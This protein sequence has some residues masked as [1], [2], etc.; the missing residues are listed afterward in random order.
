MGI[1]L[2][3]KQAN[4]K[5]I[6]CIFKL[7]KELIDKYENIHIINYERVMAWVY[8]KIKR[9]ISEYTCIFYNNKKG[10][11]FPFL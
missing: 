10:W 3:F 4:E 1:I 11:L 2:K 7:N 9:N 6:K 5:D 8:Q